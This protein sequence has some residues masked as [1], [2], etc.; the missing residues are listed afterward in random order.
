MDEQLGILNR[1]LEAVSRPVVPEAESLVQTPVLAAGVQAGTADDAGRPSGSAVVDSA[2]RP[3]E[4]AESS[5][6]GRLDTTPELALTREE[7]LASA[8]YTSADSTPVKEARWEHCVEKMLRD[9]AKEKASRQALKTTTSQVDAERPSP[10]VVDEGAASVEAGIVET[11]TSSTRDTLRRLLSGDVIPTADE[12]MEQL[13]REAAER[14][15]EKTAEMARLHAKLDALANARRQTVMA[16][17]KTRKEKRAKQQAKGRYKKRR[18]AGSSAIPLAL[19]AAKTPSADLGDDASSAMSE[20]SLDGKEPDAE[21]PAP[22]AASNAEEGECS[23]E[24]EGEFAHFNA[25]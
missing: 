16:N 20:D 10:S 3:L 18:S 7:L 5:G 15:A 1:S 6:A 21:R 8:T 9:E 19:D 25:A 22:V 13:R 23:T 2:E 12:Q 14:K 11:R 17:Q 24:S 4:D